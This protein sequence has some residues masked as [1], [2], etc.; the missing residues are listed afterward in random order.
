MGKAKRLASGSPTNIEVDKT[1]LGRVLK[2]RRLVVP[3]F[4]R[5][6]SWHAGRVK[7]LFSDFQSAMTKGQDSYFLGT[8]VFQ[9]TNP[10]CV[11]DG[12]QR[13]ATTCI[14]LA[15]VRDAY[16][17]LGATEEAKSIT[18]D[19]LFTYDRDDKEYLPR[20]L[21]NIDD[22]EYIKNSVLLEPSQ[23]QPSPD[24]KEVHSHRLIDRAFEC[25]RDRVENI[26]AGAVSDARKIEEL[27]AWVDFIEHKSVVVA[28]TPPSLSQAYQMFI[29]LNDRAQR[30]TQADLIKS[31]L[32]QE[33]SEGDTDGPH[34]TEACA[35]WAA[36]RKQTDVGVPT[37]DDPILTYLRYM[38]VIRTGP[39]TIDGLFDVIEGGIRG[40]NKALHFLDAMSQYAK[41]YRAAIGDHPQFWDDK[42]HQ[43]SKLVDH[44]VKNM[45]VNFPIPLFLAV[46]L[47]FSDKDAKL[48]LR[49][50]E[51][52]CA[53][54]VI[55]GAQRSGNAERGFG[56][57][58]HRIHKGEIKSA[59]HLI[60]ESE[61]SIV[62]SDSSFQEKFRAKT[63]SSKRQARYF[64][65]ELEAQARAEDGD[66]FAVAIDE[67]DKLSLEHILPSG[68]DWAKHYKRF[69]QDERDA[70]VSKIGNLALAKKAANGAMNDSPF[71]A[72]LPILTAQSLKTT[73][74]VETFA[75]DD[76]WTPASI[77]ERQVWLS[78]LALKRWPLFASKPK[79][80]GR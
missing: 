16:L 18:D 10:T 61:P 14:F 59:A 8:I 52:W 37:Q 54:L 76:D 26:I 71:S 60:Q 4:Q 77:D 36:A 29:T 19:F 3:G 28:L 66:V 51:S 7:K 56:L 42:A 33:V 39:V 78:Q 79:K 20:L 22:R 6:Y 58:A 80:S 65:L 57:L 38:C 1:T 75:K 72:K 73:I 55:T 43:L 27:N 50:I 47:K 13:L 74:E 48:A 24:R 69:T 67:P 32:F 21:L 68:K 2:S 11:I 49:A 64:L 34:I 45:G 9:A 44:C 25:S 35:K 17:E 23:R 30:T 31:H 63:F 46:G 41:P 53:R 12:Q 5:E 15:A 62:P 70:C 40:R